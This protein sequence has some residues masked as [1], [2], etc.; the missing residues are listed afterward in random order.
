M[1]EQVPSAPGDS[2]VEPLAPAVAD[3]PAEPEVL[4]LEVGAVAA[5][6]SCVAHAPD[7]RVV[8][9]RHTLPGERVRAVVTASTRSF[10]R[11]DAVEVL[12]ASPERVER[13]C[14]YAGP[15]RCGG[16]DWQHVALPEQRTGRV[17]RQ[18]AHPGEQQQAQPDEHGHHQRQPSKD[19]LQHARSSSQVVGGGNLAGPGARSAPRAPACRSSCRR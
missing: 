1:T 13:P 8:F 2:A 18:S 7:G 6:G 9:V 16:C 3:P 15:G 17:T 4:E 10:L 14:P 19:E 5:G 11:A 12:T